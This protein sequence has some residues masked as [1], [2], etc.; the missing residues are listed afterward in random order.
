MKIIGVVT[1][2][3][4]DYG[5]YTPLLKA[6]QD[7]PKLQLWLYVSGM[8][9]SPAFDMTV[10]Q[11]EKDGF[12]I[13]EKVE[14]LLASDTPE[15]IAKCMDWALLD[16]PRLL[17]VL[18]LIYLWSWV[19][20]FEMHAAALAALPFKIPLAHIHGGEIT[21]GAIDDSL[22]HSITKLSHLHFVSCEEYGRRVTQLG[23]APERV[24]VCGAPALD[25][26]GHLSFLQD[27][28]L[29]ERFKIKVNP[30]TVTGHL[31]P[32]HHGT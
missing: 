20:R 27:A 14:M 1:T 31:S 24:S 17:R 22:R 12:E 26:I 32:R 15:A 19:I 25:N 18:V 30:G 29:E 10:R 6:I 8:H 28:E 4:A 2:S 23:E 11:I 9:L 7:E 21:A 16:S 5:I 13:I 3:R